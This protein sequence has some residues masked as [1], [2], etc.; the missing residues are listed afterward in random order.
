MRIEV[1]GRSP[2]VVTDAIR[3]HAQAKAS[4]LPKHFDGV[5]LITIRLSRVDHKHS[6]SFSVEIVVDV[7][8][9]PDFVASASD[10]DLYAAIDLA[11]HKCERQLTD[12]KE[13]LKQGR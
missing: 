2:L 6:P 1:I 4:K 7:E 13:R 8:K 3:A 9:H 11:A 5:Q 12:F 10:P